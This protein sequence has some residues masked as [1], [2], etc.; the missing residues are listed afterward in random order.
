MASTG[1]GTGGSHG[2]TG[3]VGYVRPESQSRGASANELRHA[4]AMTALSARI[5]CESVRSTCGDAASPTQPRPERPHRP[6]RGRSWWVQERQLLRHATG[7]ESSTTQRVPREPTARSGRP[8]LCLLSESRAM[9]GTFTQSRTAAAATMPEQGARHIP[10]SEFLR[11]HA[12]VA[13][14]N[15]EAGEAKVDVDA[16][17]AS[18]RHRGR[19]GVVKA[20]V[21]AAKGKIVRRAPRGS[22]G[23]PA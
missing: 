10:K 5:L 14:T 4:K 7:R 11:A 16:S 17:H 9:S 2:Q 3:A 8:S 21:R 13:F 15:A 18:S 19:A 1:A 12:R 23:A 6:R 20:D 22:G